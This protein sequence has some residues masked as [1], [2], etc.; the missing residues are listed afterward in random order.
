MKNIGKLAV[1]GAVLAAS[2]SFAFADNLTLGSWGQAN[3]SGYGGGNPGVSNTEML[4]TANVTF[5]N[6]TTGCAPATVCL[7]NATLNNIPNVFATDLDP[8]GVWSAALGHSFWVGINSTA[9]PVGTQNPQFGYYGFSTTFSANGGLGGSYSGSFS[10]MADDTV[11]V[12]L[13][14]AAVPIAASGPFGT[15][16][17][18]ADNPPS[19]SA[20]FVL[21]FS[22]LA[23]QGS[24]T[25]TFI[26]QQAGVGPQ[27]GTNDPS[28]V[29]FDA[30]LTLNSAPEPSSLMLLGTGLVGAAGMLFRRRVTV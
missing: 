27:G 11:A 4:Y 1:L 26:V 13:N 22:S 10:V 30:N 18:C 3:L 29:D 7:P 19:C 8:G 16:I 28:G 25:L 12:F 21:N 2:A 14:G 20:P 24:N 6:D 5:T 9:G 23:L 17:K 15:D